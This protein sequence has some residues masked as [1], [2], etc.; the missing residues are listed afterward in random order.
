MTNEVLDHFKREQVNGLIVYRLNKDEG[1]AITER[2]GEVFSCCYITDEI[3][4]QLSKANNL[5]EGTFLDKYVMPDVGKIKSGDF[6]EIFSFFA[7]KDNFRMKGFT[8]DGPLKWRWKESRNK[9]APFTD[10]VLFHIDSKKYSEKDFLVTVESKM[11]ATASKDSVIQKA[12]EG[13]KEDRLPRLIKTL[14]W[15]EEKYAKE[16]DHD[17]VRIIQR[18][19]DPATYGHYDIK[20]KAFAIVDSDLSDC[21]TNDVSMVDG[22]TAVVFLIDDLQ[23]LY[24]SSRTYSIELKQCQP[25]QG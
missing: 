8:L 21:E 1:G 18:F 14:A 4:T 11:K 13:A 19:R 25:A 20:N 15:L 2:L 9:P 6:G 24:E 10:C 12:I 22:I 23:N 16:P 17:S 3:L 5:D 7:V